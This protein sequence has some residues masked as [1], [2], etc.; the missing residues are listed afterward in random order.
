[1]RKQWLESHVCLSNSWNADSY[2]VWMQMA[3]NGVSTQP[4]LLNSVLAKIVTAIN[5]GFCKTHL[6]SHRNRR[7]YLYRRTT[8]E[9]F[10]TR[11]GKKAWLLISATLIGFPVL[12]MCSQGIDL[13]VISRTDLKPGCSRDAFSWCMLKLGSW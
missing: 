13:M 12:A 2:T 6:F 7:L 5:T 8:G 9:L 4:V 1:M 3:R 11:L 10:Q